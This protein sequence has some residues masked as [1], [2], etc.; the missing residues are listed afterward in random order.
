VL[1]IH[2]YCHVLVT[3]LALLWIELYA[4]FTEPLEQ[5]PQVE[6]V[7]LER[8]VNHNYVQVHET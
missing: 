1:E 7:L 3:R 6:Q 8:V 2:Q 4:G 5:F